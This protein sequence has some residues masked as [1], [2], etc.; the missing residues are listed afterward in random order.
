LSTH[1]R[2]HYNTANEDFS[3]ESNRVLNRPL[4][5]VFRPSY[6]RRL[7]ET[8]LVLVY[9]QI[10]EFPAPTTFGLALLLAVFLALLAGAVLLDRQ[11]RHRLSRAGQISQWAA[12][13]RVIEE[14][15]LNPDEAALLRDALKRH[16][17]NEPLEAVSTRLAFGRMVDAAMRQSAGRLNENDFRQYGIRLRD[18]RIQLGLDAITLGQQILS[19]R[20]LDGGQRIEVAPEGTENWLYLHVSDVDE[21]YFYLRYRGEPPAPALPG[22]SQRVKCNLWRDED[23]RYSFVTTVVATEHAP[24]LLILAHTSELNR[25]Q[26]RNHFRVRHDQSTTIGVLSATLKDE[27][28]DL[29]LRQPVTRLRG[30]ITSLS[31][32][33][34]AVVV[35]QPVSKQ[36]L[37]RIALDLPGQKPLDLHAKI[38]STLPI[39]GARHL[40]R[41]KFVNL[42]DESVDAIS[43]HVMRKQQQLLAER[44]DKDSA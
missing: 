40:L 4:A 42:P 33:G 11:R 36:M 9:A 18:I 19:T 32:G 16:A 28:N 21:A 41:V 29:R 12:A 31:A 17:R 23:G 7:S 26:T 24:P 39:S 15:R 13:E 14:R 22:A 27:P 3:S 35:Q 43:G 1:S 25:T 2:N 30:R 34:C 38:V 10:V 44:Q 5:P 6:N 8:F 37:L 20:E